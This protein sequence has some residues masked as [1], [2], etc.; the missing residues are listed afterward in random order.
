LISGCESC[1]GIDSGLPF[2]FILSICRNQRPKGTQARI[3]LEIDFDEVIFIAIPEELIEFL[4]EVQHFPSRLDFFFI[5]H[6]F[7]FAN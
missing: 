7:S 3:L 6:F 5:L 1:G 4:D 2:L